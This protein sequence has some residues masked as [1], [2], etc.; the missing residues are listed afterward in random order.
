LSNA[1][2]GAKQAEYDYGPRRAAACSLFAFDPRAGGSLGF[3][4]VR[5]AARM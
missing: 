1:Q 3:I 5:H 2:D 4:D